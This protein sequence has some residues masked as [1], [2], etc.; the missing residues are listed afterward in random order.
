MIETNKPTRYE[1]ILTT[2]GTSE[3]DYFVAYLRRNNATGLRRYA[4]NH[5][6]LIP[7]VDLYGPWTEIDL[8]TKHHGR[9]AFTFD[10]GA[11]LTFSGRTERD[12]E[13]GGSAA[14]PSAWEAAKVAA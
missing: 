12:I 5:E 7:L 6:A 10:N 8:R 11:I 2:D 1:L 9:P 3:P 14:H 4:L 13:N